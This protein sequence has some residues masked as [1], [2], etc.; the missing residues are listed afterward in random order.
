MAKEALGV[1]IACLII[2][3]NNN[4]LL[5]SCWKMGMRFRFSLKIIAFSVSSQQFTQS[6]NSS[7]MSLIQYFAPDFLNI[8]FIIFCVPITSY[9]RESESQIIIILDLGRFSINIYSMNSHSQGSH[10]RKLFY[11]FILACRLFK[12]KC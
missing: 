11:F 10:K 3:I 8:S 2:P 7:C 1:Y 4:Q 12:L 5:G 6:G 9:P